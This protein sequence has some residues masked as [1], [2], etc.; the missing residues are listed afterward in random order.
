MGSNAIGQF[1]L[2]MVA[3][4][5]SLSVHESAHAWMSNKFGDDLA[6]LQGRITLNP[7][8]HV[9]PI[10]TLLFPAIAFFTGAPLI[11]W[12][13]PTPVNPLRWRN[14]RVANFW[15]SAAGVICN[16]I[17]AITAGILMRVLFEANLVGLRLDTFYGLVAVAQSDSL[18]AEG[19]AKLLGTFF[20]LNVALAVF[21]LL[22]IPPLDG[23]KILSSI[24]PPSF[25][26]ALEA[27]DRI[28]F[29]I[30]IIAVFTGVFGVIFRI[31]M[32]LAAYP[33]T[34]GLS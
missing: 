5:F 21:N 24:L 22:P 9:D 10:G 1:I 31:V 25:E 34:V 6:R 13:K 23:S 16:A 32:P 7:V 33:F 17:I 18:I 3:L 28:G 12:A 8:A 2:Y 20:T 19:A 27:L 4:I 30:L 11:G 15:V 14:K 29:M 26:P